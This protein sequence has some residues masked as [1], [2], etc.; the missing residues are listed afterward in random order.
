M[1]H[2]KGMLYICDDLKLEVAIPES[3]IL[4]RTLYNDDLL[5]VIAFRFA[6]GQELSAHSA[7]L[8]AMLQ[9]VEGQARVQ[10]GEEER[11]LGAG[12]LVHMPA[13][14]RHAIKAETP[15]VILLTLCKGE[16]K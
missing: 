5:K 11:M 4:N 7:P 1:A 9:V 8:P 12:A 13:N 2:D 6:E 15:L 14:L 3:G 16:R 10:L